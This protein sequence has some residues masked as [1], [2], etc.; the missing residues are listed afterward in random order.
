MS[1]FENL[2]LNFKEFIGEVGHIVFEFGELLDVHG[3]LFEFLLDDFETVEDLRAGLPA[4][5]GDQLD[6][7]FLERGELLRQVV[8]E[9]VALY[10]EAR[11]VDRQRNLLLQLLLLLLEHV[12]LLLDLVWL[13]RSLRIF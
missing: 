10:F 12:D 6:E 4:L 5:L 13:D 2:Q 1:G 11:H 7:L 9:V 3:S 8:E